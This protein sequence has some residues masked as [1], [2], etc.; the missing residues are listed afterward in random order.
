MVTLLILF[1]AIEFVKDILSEANNEVS[2]ARCRLYTSAL[3]T[4]RNNI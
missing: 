3:T 2:I 4:G 1:L